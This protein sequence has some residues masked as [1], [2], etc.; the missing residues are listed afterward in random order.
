MA[1]APM[2]TTVSLESYICP[3]AG[4]DSALAGLRTI[5]GHCLAAFLTLPNTPSVRTI[6]T[7]EGLYWY[8]HTV[9]CHWLPPYK[10][11]QEYVSWSQD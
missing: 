8:G 6:F 7:I 5:S 2:I 9:A 11:G 4:E 1:G 10:L 3:N